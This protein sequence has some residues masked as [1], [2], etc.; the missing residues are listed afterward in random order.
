MKL[1]S[2]AM[3]GERTIHMGSRRGRGEGEGSLAAMWPGRNERCK[4]PPQDRQEGS[5]SSERPM[6]GEASSVGLCASLQP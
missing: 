1:P 3:Q 4:H 5:H 6:S 2:P